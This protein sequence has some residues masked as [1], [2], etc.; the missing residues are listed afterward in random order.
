MGRGA[1]RCSVAG[2]G[3]PVHR[4]PAGAAGA[5]DEGDGEL[6]EQLP[7]DGDAGGGGRE[8]ARGHQREPV[9]REP[10][11]RVLGAEAE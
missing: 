11:G 9:L 5:R 3:E 8:G 7:G 2:G 6:R 10:H 4:G 1:V